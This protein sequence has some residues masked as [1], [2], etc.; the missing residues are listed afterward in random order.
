M[1]PAVTR[2]TIHHEGAGSCTDTN[3]GRYQGGGYTY[4]IGCTR[5]QHFRTVWDSYATLNWN[6]PDNGGSL[7]VCISGNRMEQTVT[8]NDVALIG[9]AVADARARGYVVDRPDV[10]AH[11]NSPG[12]STVCP[13]DHTM[14]VW[15]DIVAACQAGGAPAPEP[16]TDKTKGVKLTTVASP[17]GAGGRVGTAMA[18]PAFGV[19][20]LENGA[21][22][23]GDTGSGNKHVWANPDKT[24][25]DLK[26]PLIDIA[27]TVGGDGRPDGRGFVALY[28]L[29]NDQV[30][31]YVVPWA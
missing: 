1:P 17:R 22:C 15:A 24:V 2:L 28:D 3:S 26:A 10:V 13:G 14:A 19:V 27:P 16:P 23:Q 4:G 7:D 8:P 31:T 9:A 18:V 6:Y 11:R 12:S 5:W 30:G 20:A 21:R 29:G 25:Q